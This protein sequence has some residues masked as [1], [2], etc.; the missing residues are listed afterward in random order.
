[1]RK[2][3]GRYERIARL[4]VGGALPYLA[5]SRWQGKAR[6]K[7][8]SATG[9]HLVS[10]AATQTCP[11]NAAVGRNTYRA[12]ERQERTAMGDLPA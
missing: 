8:A 2:N 3:V 6:G 1:M 5:L 12:G 9:L 10:S 4:V 7:A 11:G